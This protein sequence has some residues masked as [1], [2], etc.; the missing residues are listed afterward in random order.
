MP[1]VLEHYL[2]KEA[3]QTFPQRRLKLVHYQDAISRYATQ[4]IVLK[5]TKVVICSHR[6]TE[7]DEG[8]LN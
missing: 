5:Y 6:Y 1:L 4:Y 8:T 2:S 7:R 3:L